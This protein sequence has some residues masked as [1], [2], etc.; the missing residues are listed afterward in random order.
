MTKEKRI[1]ALGKGAMKVSPT[2][3]KNTAQV[4]FLYIL[5]KFCR[6]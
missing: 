6:V 2:K 4:D 3:L 5:L 1:L